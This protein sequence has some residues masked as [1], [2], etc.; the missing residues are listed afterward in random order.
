M[1]PEIERRRG[2]DQWLGG[3]IAGIIDTAGDYA[4]VVLLGRHCRP[5]A[6]GSIICVRRSTPRADFHR[7]RENAAAG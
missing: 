4:L 5:S 1:Q 7:H 6:S 2:S 3:P